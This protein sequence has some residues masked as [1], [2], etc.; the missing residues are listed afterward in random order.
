MPCAFS[1]VF[2]TE[3]SKLLSCCK[4]PTIPDACSLVQPLDIRISMA[5]L[6]LVLMLPVGRVAPPSAAPDTDD[7]MPVVDPVV[8]PVSTS[9]ASFRAFVNAIVALVASEVSILSFLSNSSFSFIFSA[10][11]LPNIVSQFLYI[12]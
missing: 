9:V 2:T 1:L 11:V 7:V 4:L 8:I 6:L 12:P 5:C 3:V 10:A